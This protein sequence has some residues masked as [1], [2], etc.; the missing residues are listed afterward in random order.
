MPRP[1]KSDHAIQ[2]EVLSALNRDARIVPA[3]IGVEVS[4]GIVTLTGTV[5]RIEIAEA[6][7]D[8]ALSAASVR[9]VA[10]RLAMEGDIHERDDTTI[11]RTIRHA[12]GWNTA[13]P[14]ERIDT[15]VRR[16]VVT[17]R[18]GVEHWY[19]RKAAEGTAAGVAGV[20]SVHNQIQ[21][22][23]PPSSDDILQ[24][25]V[26]DALTHLPAPDVGVRVARGIV[27][28]LGEIGSGALRQ[29]AES[30]AEAAPGV[31]SVINQLRTH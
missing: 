31:R 12:F 3:Q 4:G 16:G 5:P 25:E 30:L 9:D 17:L 23:V 13:V 7:A 2:S 8:I 27:T 19:Q 29:H 1:F 15:I 11:A 28:L 10:N 18:G 20:V 26:E 24:E 14:A 21:L 6:A 22:L